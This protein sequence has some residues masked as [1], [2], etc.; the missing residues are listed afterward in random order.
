[1]GEDVGG[2]TYAEGDSNLILVERIISDRMEAGTEGS[3]S[4]R[5]CN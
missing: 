5:I 4:L 1:M 3:M 2:G